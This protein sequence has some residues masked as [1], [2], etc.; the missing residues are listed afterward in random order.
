MKPSLSSRAM[1]SLNGV[2]AQPLDLTRVELVTQA[3]HDPSSS[4]LFV[5]RPRVDDVDL[6]AWVASHRQE[7]EQRISEYGA[8]LFDGFQIG[9]SDEFRRVAEGL[10][11]ELYG[12]YGDLPRGTESEKIYAATPYPAEEAIR[13]HNEGIHTARWPLRIMFYCDQPA[14]AGGET[15]ITDCRAVA[16]SLDPAIVERFARVGCLYVRNFMFGDAYSSGLD[17]SWIE[18][19][20]TDDCAE[21]ERQ[22]C[23][24]GLEFEWGPDRSLRIS[25]RSQVVHRHPRT[26]DVVFA[27]QILTH[28]ISC[29]APAIRT[30]VLSLFDERHLPRNVYYGD[31]GAIEDSVV[32]AIEA[33]CRRHALALPWKKGNVMVLDNLL[34]AHARQP[35]TGARRI[36]V[37]MAEM[38]GEPGTGSPIA[39]TDG[40]AVKAGGDP[41]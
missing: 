25:K 28:H 21:V 3:R 32:A 15:P 34:V 9:T 19:F 24:G 31:G 41:A 12:D 33:T 13:F 1:P 40:R 30:S 16:R 39:P 11:G 37:A 35:F 23:E 4:F 17:V 14:Q 26:G 38:M 18:F 22:C 36:L 29:L 8:V 2:L 10:C 27:S 7:I 20:R 5:I 6:V